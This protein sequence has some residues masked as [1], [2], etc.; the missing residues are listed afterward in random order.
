METP[1][2]AALLAGGK[3]SRMGQDKA[4]LTFEG[5][6]LWK[7]QIGLL[8]SLKPAQLLISGR[9]DGPY[10]DSGYEIVQDHQKNLG[11]LA[12]LQSVLEQCR[13]TR[14]LLLAVDMPWMTHSVLNKLSS[15]KACLVPWHDNWWEGTVAVYP[16]NILPLVNG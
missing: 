7:R 15:S 2:T 8:E 5:Q 10:A 6:L 12:G 1:F 11:P 9:K 3:S 16:V 13:T 4:T 14:L